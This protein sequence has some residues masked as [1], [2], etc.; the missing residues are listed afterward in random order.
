MKAVVLLVVALAGLACV[1]CRQHD[2]RTTTIT[3]PRVTAGKAA[4]IVVRA[5]SRTDGVLP[6][7]IR[8]ESGKVTVTYDSMKVAIKNLEYVIAEA[9][10]DAGEFPADPKAKETLPEELR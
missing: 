4:D 7:S 8:I 3:C 2:V 10:F 1:S 5:L 9:G 6:E